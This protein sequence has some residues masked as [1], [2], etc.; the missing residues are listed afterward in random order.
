MCRVVFVYFMPRGITNFLLPPVPHLIHSILGFVSNGNWWWWAPESTL[1]SGFIQFYFLLHVTYLFPSFFGRHWFQFY[2]FYSFL[3]IEIIYFR[4]CVCEKWNMHGL[5]SPRP[6]CQT[7]TPA[8]HPVGT[9][10][11]KH[12]PAVTA[13]SQNLPKVEINRSWRWLERGEGL[14]ERSALNW[15]C[16][17]FGLDC[18]EGGLPM[19]RLYFSNHSSCTP[20]T[21]LASLAFSPFFPV[22]PLGFILVLCVF[23]LHY[24]F[25]YIFIILK[26][27]CHGF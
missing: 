26:V 6:N 25:L 22:L 10:G 18:R 12:E 17:L 27:T 2:F 20:T 16:S 24:N 15:M 23:L 8:K 4:F 21:K 1:L 7:K 14:K 3:F 9:S 5:S 13:G 19:A 11:P